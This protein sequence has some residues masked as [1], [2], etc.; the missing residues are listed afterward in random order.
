MYQSSAAT[1]SGNRSRPATPA[2][3]T[4][5]TP[6]PP[7]PR[8]R[9]H[10]A[11]TAAGVND[12]RPSG[13]G[14]STKSFCV[15]WPLANS[16]RSGYVPPYPQRVL[17]VV[18]GGAVEPRDAMV[19][20]EPRALAADIAAGAEEGRLAG[21]RPVAALVEIGEH[22]GISQ[23]TRRGDSVAQARVQQSR[24]L[25]DK[26]VGEHLVRPLH[27]PLIETSCVGIQSDDRGFPPRRADH[28]R[29]GREGLPGEFDDLQRA[30]D[31]A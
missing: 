13:S 22:L 23:S 12:S 10:N 17:D 8:R 18:R 28:R 26:T 27:Q 21:G 6:S 19:A 9:S 11:A 16:T 3:V 30:H 25:A 15:P 1:P 4:R 7:S 20:A 5:S 29:R 2:L 24:C 14:S 31:T